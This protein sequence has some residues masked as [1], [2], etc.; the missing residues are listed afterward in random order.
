MDSSPVARSYEE[1]RDRF[2]RSRE[3]EDARGLRLG[4]VRLAVFILGFSLYVA[5]DLSSGPVRGVV[6]GGSM[7]AGLVFVALVVVHRRVRAR[8]KR[9]GALAKINEEALARLRRDWDALPPSPM[10][11]TTSEHPFAL[12]LDVCGEA[13]L[14]RL[15]CTVTLPPGVETLRGWL[16]GPASLTEVRRRQK[17]VA[18]LAPQLHLRQTLEADGRLLSSPSQSSIDGFL[19][20]AE[21]E[22]WLPGHRW[23]LVG[24]WLL[25]LATLVLG[26]LYMRGSV[27][28]T[29]PFLSLAASFILATSN[30]MRIHALLELASA[31]GERFGRY[32][33]LL[34]RLA[35]MDAEAPALRELRDT[36]LSSPVGPERELRRLDR[37]VSCGNIRYSSMAHSPL[38]AFLVWDIHVLASLERW[39]ARS[40]PHVR[41]WLQALG[42]LEA[43]SAL[44]ALKA[45]HPDWC[46]PVAPPPF[47]E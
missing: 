22:P 3:E 17:A 25:P 4:W 46:F 7:V 32:G 8:Q 34:A 33:A 24:A 18:E 5:W 26:S 45:D 11:G 15:L 47:F 28:V 38:Q 27:P 16:L 6:G 10:S 20:W 31:G 36:V 14:F 42:T 9:Y 29:W 21:E 2:D 40:G 23:V 1:R 41:S 39:K 35:E 37:T 13:S 19:D 43:L 30:Q 44:A 12:D